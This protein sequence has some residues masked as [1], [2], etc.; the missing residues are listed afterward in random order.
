L[1]ASAVLSKTGITDKLGKFK[2]PADAFIVG[3]TGTATAE[4]FTYAAGRAGL[5]AAGRAA[6]VAGTEMSLGAAAG[7]VAK[8]FGKGGLVAIPLVV[9][10]YFLEKGIHSTTG[11]SHAVSGGIS[12]GLV[13]I[14]AGAAAGGPVG[15]A[16]MFALSLGLGVWGGH[17]KDK[18][19]AKQANEEA[20]RK[21]EL[22]VQKI[23]SQ[24]FQKASFYRNR[25]IETLP[26]YNYDIDK[27]LKNYTYSN[28]LQ[29]GTPDYNNWL[30][31]VR[32]T[33]SAPTKA[34][35]SSPILT[36]DQ[37][38]V[39]QLF[40]QQILHTIGTRQKLEDVPPHLTGAELRFLNDRTNNNALD[41]IDN[42]VK[43][44]LAHNEYLVK[45]TNE[46]RQTAIDAFNNDG[47]IITQ[48]DADTQAF[49]HADH[50]FEQVYY[51]DVV[52][53]SREKIINAWYNDQKKYQALDANTTM[54]AFTGH[55]AAQFT[56]GLNKLYRLTEQ[57]AL[58]LGISV[59]D[60]QKLQATPEAEQASLYE[61]MTQVNKE[62]TNLDEVVA[63]GAYH[64]THED[65]NST[66]PGMHTE[67]V[68]KQ[69]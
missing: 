8:G 15:A 2:M 62:D 34:N 51:R 4:A 57:N 32:G 35:L 47:K 49:L 55:D 31:S 25:F 17:E 27:A 30:K 54:M 26:K 44:T 58:G 19:E 11:A 67:E 64:D 66:D 3:G 36:D 39:Q 42:Q 43:L 22:Q 12:G 1:A 61:S 6:T 46:A 37:L 40:A 41:I 60:Y 9:G 69:S 16:V 63:E 13:G 59:A 33:F 56:S 18:E 20:Q 5:T 21:Y 7:T 45:Q 53:I 28:G 38:K 68:K 23:N 14:A 48:L 24:N 65:I 29:S 10:D 50:E 52:D